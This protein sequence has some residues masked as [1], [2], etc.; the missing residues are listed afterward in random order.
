MANGAM[1]IEDWDRMRELLMQGQDPGPDTINVHAG[2]SDNQLRSIM[3]SGA[4]IMCDKA[5][6]ERCLRLQG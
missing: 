3:K 1:T 6:Y 2:W 4:T 5:T